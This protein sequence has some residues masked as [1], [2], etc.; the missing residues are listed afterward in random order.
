MSSLLNA[1][2]AALVPSSYLVD[3]ASRLVTE[4]RGLERLLAAA[5]LPAHP[6]ESDMLSLEQLLGALAW[7]DAR[8]P[9]G[10]HIEASLGLDASQ[11]GAAGL[12][13]ITA[14]N[15]DQ[16]LSTLVGFESLRA[17]WSTLRREHGR[18]RARLIT[19]ARLP[20][21]G[22][23]HLLMEMT[24]L[25]QF[26]LLG[27]LGPAVRGRL[28]LIL[29]RRYRPWQDQLEQSLGAGL[30]C[31]G[32]GYRIELP[33]DC[34][35]LPCL[36]RDT[37]LHRTAIKRCQRDLKE[38][39]G[40]GPLSLRVYQQLLSNPGHPNTLDTLA[41]TLGQSSRTLARRLKTEGT[42]WRL[43][44]ESALSLLAADALREGLEPIGQIAQRL[45][46]ADPANF[47]RACHRW[48]GCGPGTFRQRGSARTD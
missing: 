42:S 1:G 20:D 2:P 40:L 38:R 30:G 4:P 35:A 18:T 5:Q 39:Q 22:P 24:L 17:P 25:A 6:G 41:R 16:A 7:L 3:I 31:E 36:L 15:V 21:G 12:A 48:W 8:L 29:P 34:L 47:N 46:Y 28:R 37:E 43:L 14:A 45:G 19:S 11:H 9:R 10:W 32:A 44:R 33:L 13:V 23:H 27:Q 26:S